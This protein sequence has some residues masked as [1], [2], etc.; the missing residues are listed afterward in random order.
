MPGAREATDSP[1]CPTQGR[2]HT[3]THTHTHTL[4]LPA[5]LPNS[6]SLL[7]TPILVLNGD[8]NSVA[9]TCPLPREDEDEVI[10]HLP[11]SPSAL[12]E[13]DRAWGSQISYS[14]KPSW[15]SGK[16]GHFSLGTRRPRKG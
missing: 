12:S 15:W 5:Q 2:A 10:S 16:K 3:H 4:S 7:T 13:S 6:L 8:G 14:P 11:F 9:D 1:A